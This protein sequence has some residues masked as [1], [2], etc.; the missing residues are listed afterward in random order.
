MNCVSTTISK[1]AYC[2]F[3]CSSEEITAHSGEEL[4]S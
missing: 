3:K 2:S 4:S 1:N